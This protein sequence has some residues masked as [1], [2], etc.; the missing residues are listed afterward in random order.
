MEQHCPVLLRWRLGM[1]VAN[2]DGYAVMCMRTPQRRAASFQF[3]ES[4]RAA[5]IGGIKNHPRDQCQHGPMAGW[6]SGT[7]QDPTW[8][9]WNTTG[10]YKRQFYLGHLWHRLQVT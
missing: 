6:P 5:R 7:P 1:V 4:E 3:G 10:A 9:D 8:T 2:E